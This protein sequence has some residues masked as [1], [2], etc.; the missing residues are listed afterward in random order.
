ML[1]VLALPALAQNGR[2]DVARARDMLKRTVEVVKKSYYDPSLHGVDLD[3][4]AK[5]AEDNIGK[6]GD[7]GAA[8]GNIAWVL[9]SLNDSHTHFLPPRRPYHAENGWVVTP[10]GSRCYVTAVKPGSDAAAQG[11]KPGDQLLEWNGFPVTP[12][13]LWKMEYSFNLLA[14]REAH[15]LVVATSGEQPRK[16]MV[17]VQYVPT[18]RIHLS[19]IPP[20]WEDNRELLKTRF[21]T[22]GSNVLIARFST[23]E[24][25][26]S[27]SDELFEKA[28]HYDTFVLDL[29]GNGGG[30][31]EGLLRMLGHLFNHPVKL[32]EL[33]TRKG[34]KDLK[35]KPRGS[36]FDGSLIVLIDGRSASSAELFARI[37]QLEKRGIVIGDCS[38]GMVMRSEVVPLVQGDEANWLTF[39][40]QVTVSDLIM[41]DG[42]SLEHNPVKPDEIVLPTQ[43]DLADGRDPV[44]TVPLNWQV[45]RS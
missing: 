42:K 26:Q 43:D 27:Q 28:R 37:I 29:R 17:K 44:L 12:A 1:L 10:V 6:A 21:A 22:L 40:V 31:E 34:K 4:R 41:A 30:S 13:A 24:N 23:F 38:S 39:G 16:V 36:H 35:V 9:D 25:D 8:F 45:Y 32:G 33:V 5:T 18:E 3:G 14:P 15:A 2:Y 20:D 11:L 19:R 7:F